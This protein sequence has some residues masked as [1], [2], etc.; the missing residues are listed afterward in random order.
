MNPLLIGRL[1]TNISPRKE[2]AINETKEEEV[3]L[4]SEY[5][6]TYNETNHLQLPKGTYCAYFCD[7]AISPYPLNTTDVSSGCNK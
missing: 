7:F 1:G 5:T 4:D 3:G 2:I 6:I